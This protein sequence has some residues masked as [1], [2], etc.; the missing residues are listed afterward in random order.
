[1]NLVYPDFSTDFT[2]SVVTYTEKDTT[3]VFNRKPHAIRT[4]N[5]ETVGLSIGFIAVGWQL[6]AICWE[7]FS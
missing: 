7:V 5:R 3:D 2:S 4:S 6:L 1:M